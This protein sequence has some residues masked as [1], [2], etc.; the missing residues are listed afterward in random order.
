[1]KSSARFLLVLVF[2]ALVGID[3]EYATARP[4]PYHEIPAPELV[5]DPDVCLVPEKVA[6]NFA[7]RPRHPLESKTSAT[8]TFQIKNTCDQDIVHRISF[9]GGTDTW[10]EDLS[11]RMLGDD[12][13]V[14]GLPIKVQAEKMTLLDGKDITEELTALGLPLDLP[15][16]WQFTNDYEGIIQELQ[17][18]NPMFTE[19]VTTDFCP[20]WAVQYSFWFNQTF[21]AQSTTTI[22]YRTFLYDGYGI[23]SKYDGNLNG[24]AIWYSSYS[25]SDEQKSAAIQGVLDYHNLSDGL[26]GE[27]LM[28]IVRE[29]YGEHPYAYATVYWNSV[30]LG[31]TKWQHPI[32]KL[33]IEYT[34]DWEDPERGEIVVF[35]LNGKTHIKINNFALE[36][37]DYI[38]A[39]QPLTFYEFSFETSKIAIEEIVIDATKFIETGEYYFDC[40]LQH[41]VA[42]QPKPF[43]VEKVYE[44][45]GIS[46]TYVGTMKKYNDFIKQEITRPEFFDDLTYQY[47]VIIK[48]E[49]PEIFWDNYY[50]FISL[51]GMMFIISV[52]DYGP[53]LKFYDHSGKEIAVAMYLFKPENVN[54][55]DFKTYE[56]LLEQA[57]NSCPYVQ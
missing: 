29:L 27:E 15:T 10:F 11:F 53:S 32:G 5:F 28:G 51:D 22:E 57:K 7:S 46:A 2:V 25:F 42:R 34:T 14:D 50:K 9:N 17:L 1:M 16:Y 24:I 56:E 39:E 6:I 4:T 21:P 44:G 30:F 35:R 36:F 52:T 45:C 40:N 23:V 33:R 43:P 38:P 47:S 3:C 37:N 20:A 55:P 8:L 31:A 12:V 18:D 13:K 49:S 19:F 41:L 54:D 26:S 48:Q